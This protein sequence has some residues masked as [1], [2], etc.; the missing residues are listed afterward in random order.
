[1][2]IFMKI[3][4]I[5]AGSAADQGFAGWIPLTELEFG[6][7]RKITSASSTG[8][9]RESANATITDLELTRLMD[10][11]TPALFIE[12]CC[13]RGRAIT[14]ALTRTGTGNGA[15]IYATYVLGNALI[16]S[17]RV[18]ANAQHLTRPMEKLRIS[19][20]DMELRY[21]PYDQDGKAQAPSAVGFD[22][23]T[24]TKR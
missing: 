18:E 17:Y 4:G 23:T 10:R 16:S 14:L 8:G 22:A 15:E 9:D 5:D 6:T 12:S 3:D 13:G 7:S 1:M 21:T 11:S 2:S 19:F 24:N 20:Q